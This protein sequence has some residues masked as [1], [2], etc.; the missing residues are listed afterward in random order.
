MIQASFGLDLDITL[1]QHLGPT[2]LKGLVSAVAH[3]WYS[4]FTKKKKEKWWQ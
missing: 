3:G 1:T 4:V 2:M